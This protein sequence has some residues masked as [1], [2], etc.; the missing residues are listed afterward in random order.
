M[1]SKTPFKAG[2]DILTPKVPIKILDGQVVEIC[3][4]RAPRRITKSGISRE[5][6]HWRL[7]V[8]RLRAVL[9]QEAEVMATVHERI[10]LDNVSHLSV[11]AFSRK[12]INVG[13][14]SNRTER[15]PVPGVDG[16]VQRPGKKSIIL[17]PVGQRKKTAHLCAG[18]QVDIGPE[19]DG[20]RIIIWRQIVLP[21]NLT[22]SVRSAARRSTSL[23]VSN[24]KRVFEGQRFD[25]IAK[26]RKIVFHT[27][28]PSCAMKLRSQLEAV[29]PLVDRL[30]K[31]LSYTFPEPSDVPNPVPRNGSADE[32]ACGHRASPPI[33]QPTK[34]AIE[35][36]VLRRQVTLSEEDLIPAE[37]RLGQGS[38]SQLLTH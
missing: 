3:P 12:L 15:V 29:R 24:S 36:D 11:K 21:P 4:R 30:E 1:P 17:C 34:L 18:G 22:E 23:V 33:S 28:I 10:F 6:Y 2:V 16:C 7:I 35:F 8:Q 37:P 5:H 19:S 14:I 31:F 20:V 9:S 26:E 25:T 32:R 13:G 27:G 38:S